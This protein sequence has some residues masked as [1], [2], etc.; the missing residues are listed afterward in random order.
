MEDWRQDL[1]VCIQNSTTERLPRS[2]SFHR[3]SSDEFVPMRSSSS[4]DSGG[5]SLM[6][7]QKGLVRDIPSPQPKR[8]YTYLSVAPD[9]ILWKDVPILLEE[10][11]A[12]ARELQKLRAKLGQ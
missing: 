5:S 4:S 1:D 8:E 3:S 9:E 10:Y 11:K 7:S 2:V 6:L 12:M